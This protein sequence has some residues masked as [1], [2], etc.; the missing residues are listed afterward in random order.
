MQHLIDNFPPGELL[1]I[2]S[3]ANKHRLLTTEDKRYLIALRMSAPYAD[4]NYRIEDSK[5][6]EFPRVFEDFLTGLETGAGCGEEGCSICNRFQ[7][8]KSHTEAARPENGFTENARPENGGQ[9]TAA[10]SAADEPSS[11]M[12]SYTMEPEE[13]ELAR[14]E[15]ISISQAR[16]KMALK[17]REE[18]LAKT[19]ERRNQEGRNR[20]K[21]KV[22]MKRNDAARQTADSSADPEP[23]VTR[24][25][26]DALPA[27][28]ASATSSGEGLKTDIQT[29]LREAAA[30]DAEALS[31]RNLLEYAEECRRL[32]S[33]AAEQLD[34]SNAEQQP[35]YAPEDESDWLENRRMYASA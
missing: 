14:P 17:R 10:A 35:D 7:V 21:V 20:K 13:D 31:A 25:E 11:A 33:L 27:E 15:D 3:V 29:L 22:K 28:G 1:H 30:V 18:R 19:R 5:K 12:S 26:S 16:T 4:G 34:S 32:M 8:L 2:V 6:E 9:D 23:A 24:H